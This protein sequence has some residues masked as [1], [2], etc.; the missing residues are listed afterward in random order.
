MNVLKHIGGDGAEN[1]NKK[2]LKIAI[3]SIKKY[4]IRQKIKHF[5]TKKWK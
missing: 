4:Q 5:K 3:V 1:Y 2:L